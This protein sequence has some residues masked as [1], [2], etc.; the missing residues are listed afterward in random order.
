[1]A[2]NVSALQKHYRLVVTI[3]SM[4][5]TKSVFFLLFKMVAYGDDLSLLVSTGI[6]RYL[7]SQSFGP[8]YVTAF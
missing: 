5:R 6:T 7:L 3:K 4:T 2:Y 1:M 8:F